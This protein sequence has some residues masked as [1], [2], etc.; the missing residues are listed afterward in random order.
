MNTVRRLGFFSL[1]RFV[2]LPD[3]VG[4]LIGQPCQLHTVETVED[5]EG[6]APEYAAFAKAFPNTAVMESREYIS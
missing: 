5:G 3:P 2:L 4:S 1:P 6:G